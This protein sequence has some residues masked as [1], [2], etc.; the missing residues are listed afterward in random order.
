[1]KITSIL[2][3]RLFFSGKKSFRKKFQVVLRNV[4]SSVSEI[5]S[6]TFAVAVLHQPT[7]YNGLIHEQKQCQNQRA[8]IFGRQNVTRKASVNGSE[9]SCRPP[10]CSGREHLP[11]EEGLRDP[12]WFSLGGD[13]EEAPSAHKE[14]MEEMEPGSSQLCL[15][16]G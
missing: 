2:V 3:V 4:M 14:V 8:I 16:E 11:C 13:L 10:R 1:M 9:F 12:G 15:V 5:P 6:M 7:A